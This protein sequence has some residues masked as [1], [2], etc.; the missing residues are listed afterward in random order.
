MLEAEKLQ[1]LEVEGAAEEAEKQ[2]VAFEAE[3]L[4]DP[5]SSQSPAS[6]GAGATSFIHVQQNGGWPD[7]HS[8]TKVVDLTNFSLFDW[9]VQVSR[10]Q[11]S[12]NMEK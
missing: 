3:Q 11:K 8:G 7:M 12:L 1:Q 6:G 10:R 2:R 4:H 5:A 9:I